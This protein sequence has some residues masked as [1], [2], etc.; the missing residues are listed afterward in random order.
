MQTL[1]FSALFGTLSSTQQV[2]DVTFGRE[3]SFP[4]WF[5]LIAVLAGTGSLLNATIVVR[6]G[7][8]RVI[9]ATLA[10]QVVLSAGFALM[11]LAGLWPEALYF[12]AYIAWTTNVFFMAGLTFGNLNA[13]A[14]EPVG[15][16][17]GM[18]SSIVGAASTVGAVFV[19]VPIG[20][21][22]IGTACV[23]GFFYERIR[24][25]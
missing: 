13:L 24:R 21:V 25:R 18:A 23:R 17:A 11:T 10:M 14:L 16:I 20:L 9:T 4:L 22:A 3:A 19:A 2:F 5:G 8:R 15:H 7:M 12:P 6:L 1:G